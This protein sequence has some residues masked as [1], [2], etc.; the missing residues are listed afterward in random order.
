MRRLSVRT[1]L[2]LW[3]AGCLVAAVVGFGAG[4][5]ALF[6]RYMLGEV[7]RAIE[8]EILE[9]SE[10][11]RTAPA[12]ELRPRL[13]D[14]FGEH[15]FYRIEVTG[16]EGESIFRTPPG[17]PLTLTGVPSGGGY[18]RKTVAISGSQPHRLIAERVQRPEGA[19]T[20]VV[21]DALTSYRQTLGRLIVALAV[22][23]PAA[24]ALAVLGGC[25][26]SRRALAPVDRLTQA[27]LSITATGLDRRVPEDGIDDEVDR[28]AA[29]F[30]VMISGL[31]AAF[32]EVRRFAAD[33]AHEL[34][35]PLAVLRT[36]AEVALRSGGTAADYR[37]A[38]SDQLEEIERL[39]RLADQL[40]FLCR[41]DARHHADDAEEVRF[42][43]L[44]EELC[45]TLQ[46]SAADRELTLACDAASSCVVVAEADRL[47]RLT[48]NL[49]DNALRYTPPG[50]R[51]D[52]RLVMEDGRARL[53]IDND[54][55]GIDP[56]HLPHLFKRFYRG[57]ASR[58]RATGGSGL[59]LAICKSIVDSLGG[60]IGLA[61]RANGG[62]I[63]TLRLPALA[64]ASASRSEEAISTVAAES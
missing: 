9:V 1:Q 49:L 30:N 55:P 15:P 2:T 44:L 41:E 22:L 18:L 25:W 54:G 35:T 34:R 11:V 40:L 12:G 19:F 26:L 31:E 20:V 60:E 8:E 59:G 21:A 53:T 39:S 6:G 63:T 58:N 23:G 50:G 28:L 61:N 43:L 48:L 29:A 10:A 27:A 32:D 16:P 56:K 46:P 57:D 3:F 14:E 5:Y 38:L 62:T 64:I 7:D 13:D 47:R 36:G 52:A 4:V 51:I 33:A 24:A 45:E 42:D 17:P 37:R